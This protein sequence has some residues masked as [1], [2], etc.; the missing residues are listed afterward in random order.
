[1]INFNIGIN[2]G[3]T[4]YRVDTDLEYC[5]FEVSEKVVHSIEFFNNKILLKENPLNPRTDIHSCT[6]C[7]ADQID[8][9]KMFLGSYRIFSS[10]EKAQAFSEE[11]KKEYEVDR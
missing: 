2:I 10:K 11:L 8:T 6:I 9:E 1:M 5:D 3:D 4:L 7:E